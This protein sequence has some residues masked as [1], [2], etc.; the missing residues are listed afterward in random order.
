MDMRKRLVLLA[1]LLFVSVPFANCSV[2]VTDSVPT[3]E[4][5]AYTDSDI[6]WSPVVDVINEDAA[7]DFDGINDYATVDDT[8]RLSFGDGA[9]DSD[10][11]VSCWMK[12]NSLIPYQTLVG[13]HETGIGKEYRLFLWTTGKVYSALFDD[14]TGGVI[15]RYYSTVLLVDTWYHVVSTYDG[16]GITGIKIYIDG[17][18]RDDHNYIAGAYTAMEDTDTKLLIGMADTSPI[19]HPFN[20]TIDEVRIYNRALSPT[21]ITEQYNG[22]FSDDTG[23]V[24]WARG[25]GNILD[26]SGEGNDGTLYGGMGYSFDGKL[27]LPITTEFDGTTTN[28]LV[29]ATTSDII[30]P[31]NHTVKAPST[32]G[33]YDVLTST[34]GAIGNF[35]YADYLIVDAPTP[36]AGTSLLT[37]IIGIFIFLA[38]MLSRR[39][40]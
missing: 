22:I 17:V 18:R 10:F 11:S 15:A 25:D 8:P 21:E 33:Y 23:L 4:P 12:A 26:Y 27:N 19:T 34:P 14:S 35:T 9:V 37:F 32:M 3:P 31:L 24:L 16:T 40:R 6:L 36:P 30:Y 7:L 38:L 2:E 29:N 20:G 13:K 39:L 1:L 5:P 28:F